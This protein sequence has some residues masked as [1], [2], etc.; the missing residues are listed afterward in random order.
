M[1][2]DSEKYEI[3]E[4]CIQINNI[5]LLRKHMNN[6]KYD[7]SIDEAWL[8]LYSV[9]NGSNEIFK[10][11]VEKCDRIDCYLIKITRHAEIYDNE[12]CKQVLQNQV[13]L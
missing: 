3:I 2:I 9:Q 10:Y 8:L 7:P 12:E 13:T 1:N 4:N 5:K 6:I 11:I